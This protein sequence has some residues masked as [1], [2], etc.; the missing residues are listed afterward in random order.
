[1]LTKSQICACLLATLLFPGIITSQAAAKKN[2]ED[3]RALD[4]LGKTY[5][6]VVEPNANPKNLVN[7][8]KLIHQVIERIA[9]SYIEPLSI[10]ELANYS[11]NAIRRYPS[12][13]S[14][15][16]LADAAIHEM[17]VRLGDPY[18]V[19][20]RPFRPQ[21]EKRVGTI[22]IEATIVDGRMVVIS[23][24]EGGPAQQAGVKPGDLI[25]T[26]DRKEVD[27]LTLEEAMKRIRG[28]IGTEVLLHIQRGGARKLGLPVT[29]TRFRVREL[30]YNV[31]GD[32]AHIRIAFFGPNTEKL[33]RKSLDAIKQEIGGAEPSGYIIDLRNNPG[34]L[35]GQ[36]ILLADTFL[37]QGMIVTTAGR[38]VLG[39]QRYDAYRG[40]IAK[41]RPILILQNGASA[42]AS[43]IFSAALKHNRRAVIM[44]TRSYGKGVVQTRFPLGAQ[45]QIT[46]TTHKYMTA[47]GTQ[48]H[49]L[50]IL[51]H[52]V[53]NGD[54][55]P[56]YG[57]ATISR[58]QCPTAGEERDRMLGCAILF[59]N[60]GPSIDAFRKGLRQLK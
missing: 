14:P 44:G 4:L 47:A 41:S 27:G 20:D 15:K 36:A 45:G 46:F 13:T 33:L 3:L 51:P 55:R 12:G 16:N 2:Y 50:G 21:K 6:S 24:L 35:V 52:I 39:A 59:L 58:D 56:A 25:V 40:D 34:G 32:I 7:S 42:S 30:R 57:A 8:L 60:K 37:E 43:E 54:P 26:I 48:I 11:S 31:L 10:R 23:P 19:F 18:A 38:N 53:I 1:M 5:H 17:V 29:R 28:P 49:G 9:R 22:G